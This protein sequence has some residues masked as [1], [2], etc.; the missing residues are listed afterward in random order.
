MPP[1]AATLTVCPDNTAPEYRPDPLDILPVRHYIDPLGT[2]SIFLHFLGISP[3][4]LD[5]PSPLGNIAL[6]HSI[7]SQF[8]TIS[9]LLALG[10]Y[11]ST[12]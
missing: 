1:V 5:I 9:T 8:A 12:S 11:S 10:R 2:R 6:D 7:F 4:P 3:N